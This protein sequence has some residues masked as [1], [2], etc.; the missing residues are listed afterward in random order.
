MLVPVTVVGGVT[1]AVMDVVHVVAVRD[2]DVAATCP[3]LV[4]V[5]LVCLVG[6]GDLLQLRCSLR[7]VFNDRLDI[8]R[9]Q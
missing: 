5:V 1:V 6:H 2:G 4:L 9:F 7:A 3:V 8:T